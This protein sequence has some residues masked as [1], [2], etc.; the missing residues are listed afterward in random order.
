MSESS[1]PGEGITDPARAAR[2]RP[3]RRRRGIPWFD[4]VGGLAVAA[5]AAIMLL[6]FRALE[7]PREEVSLHVDP[8]ALAEGFR[9]GVQ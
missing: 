6:D 8:Q 1:V 3:P 4:L 9:E 2:A 7:A 5:F